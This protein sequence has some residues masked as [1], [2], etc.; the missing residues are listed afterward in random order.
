V[1][2]RKGF[3]L[4]ALKSDEVGL[5]KTVAGNKDEK[6][7]LI[8]MGIYYFISMKHSPELTFIDQKSG[9]FSFVV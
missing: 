4:L 3:C 6:I 9:N 1:R 2:N 5:N 8:T 7:K